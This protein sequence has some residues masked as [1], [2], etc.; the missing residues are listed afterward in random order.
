M[1]DNNSADK[2]QG[3]TK[4]ILI[5]SNTLIFQRLTSVIWKT[6]LN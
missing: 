3:E 6:T 1:S 4:P 5:I 2:N